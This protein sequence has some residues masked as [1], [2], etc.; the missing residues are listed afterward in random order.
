MRTYYNIFR[1]SHG[2]G[3]YDRCLYQRLCSR[4]HYFSAFTSISLVFC[5]YLSLNVALLTIT[6][7]YHLPLRHHVAIDFLQYC[8]RMEPRLCCRP[9]SCCNTGG[10]W[11]SIQDSAEGWKVSDSRS[12]RLTEW[13][14]DLCA[15]TPSRH[16]PPLPYPSSSN[17]RFQLSSFTENAEGGMLLGVLHI[18]WQ[19]PRRSKYQWK[20]RM[21]RGLLARHRRWKT[22]EM[23][24]RTM[25][26]FHRC[27]VLEEQRCH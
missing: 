10:H 22:E 9:G 1:A 18:R 11:N 20:R 16:R 2:F 12:C 14:S 26:R 24:A 21:T 7:F 17:V 27:L 15:V 6:P 23:E 3:A 25:S 8:R 4:H 19:R 5:L 13:P